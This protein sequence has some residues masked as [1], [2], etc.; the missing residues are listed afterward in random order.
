M[1]KALLYY[2]KAR[3]KYYEHLVLTD[4]ASRIIKKFWVYLDTNGINNTA[5]GKLL[6]CTG[7]HIGRYRNLVE[8][9]TL[10]KYFRIKEI[11]KIA[12]TRRD[13][14]Y[15]YAE[16]VYPPYEIIGRLQRLLKTWK[17]TVGY[18]ALSRI[19]HMREQSIEAA[20]KYT[21]ERSPNKYAQVMFWIADEEHRRGYSDALKFYR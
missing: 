10:E 13:I 9:P 15:A 14:N 6:S 2:P 21:S 7:C 11:L 1:Y 8:V 16:I 5:A 17:N 20:V 12:K 4:Y 18:T 3:Q 19:L